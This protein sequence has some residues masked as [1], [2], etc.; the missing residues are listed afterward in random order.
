MATDDIIGLLEKPKLRK[1]L[2]DDLERS[3]TLSIE[4]T[5]LGALEDWEKVD[6]VDYVDLTMSLIVSSMSQS[7]SPL[8]RQHV[9]DKIAPPSPVTTHDLVHAWTELISIDDDGKLTLDF[10]DRY[11]LFLHR[12][13]RVLL[14]F[15]TSSPFPLSGLHIRCADTEVSDEPLCIGNLTFRLFERAQES[16]AEPISWDYS[17]GRLRVFFG[18]VEGVM[19]ETA[20]TNLINEFPDLIRSILRTVLL[21]DDN[22]SVSL[23]GV[24]LSKDSPLFG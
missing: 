5:R 4:L 7:I 14:K 22:N 24:P 17:Y 13:R 15:R 18:C 9:I 8:F 10:D 2:Q 23:R 1:E 3:R 16:D 12:V 11:N 20:L 6:D 19:S 21:R